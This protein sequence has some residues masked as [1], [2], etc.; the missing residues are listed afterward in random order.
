MLK[1]REQKIGALLYDYLIEGFKKSKNGYE[2]IKS[3]FL[4]LL[5]DFFSQKPKEKPDVYALEAFA[6]NLFYYTG[7]ADLIKNVIQNL[8]MLLIQPQT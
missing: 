4:M 5:K 8:P 1:N 3:S 2:V 6:G 7:M